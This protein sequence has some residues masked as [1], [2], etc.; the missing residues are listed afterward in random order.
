[1][2]EA[3]DAVF[4]PLLA[5]RTAA[6]KAPL[7]GAVD[8]LNGNAI[9]QRVESATRQAASKGVTDPAR[10]R[11]LVARAL[12]TLEPLRRALLA[13][14]ELAPVASSDEGW[15]QWVEQLRRV[16]A[17]ADGSC[18]ALVMVLDE[19]PEQEAPPRW[20]ARTSR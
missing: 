10:S 20:Y 12:E 7:D 9:L 8:A 15:T 17:A 18:R 16:F 1:M 2:D 13:L 19:R 4:G 5:A 11:A 6:A 14:D 3:H